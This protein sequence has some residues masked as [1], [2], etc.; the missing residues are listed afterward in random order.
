MCYRREVSTVKKL[1][2][3]RLFY[4]NRV[5]APEGEMATLSLLVIYWMLRH[6]RV[7]L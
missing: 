3:R 6:R 7:N 4:F 2:V 5:L 1:P